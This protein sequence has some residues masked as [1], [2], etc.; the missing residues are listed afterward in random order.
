[1]VFDPFGGLLRDVLTGVEQVG[2]A[3]IGQERVR[4]A[5][6]G[7][8][9]AGKTVFLTSL[10]ANLL[11]AGRGQRTLAALQDAAGG[12]LV[13]ARLVPAGAE[14]VPRFDVH[15][16]LAA[17]AEDPPAWP[18]RTDDLSSLELVLELERASLFGG[19]LGPRTVTLELLDYPG[20]WLLDLPMLDQ[21]FADWSAATL[22]RLRAPERRPA[23]APFLAFL[24]A[25]PAAAPGEE[26]LARHG[27]GLYRDALRACR[28]QLGFRYL[29]PGRVLNPGPRGDAPILWFFPLPD[30]QA[31][32]LAGLLRR[33]HA[34]YVEEQRERFFDPFF[35]RFQRQ[36]VLVDVL[37]A[38]HAGPTAF[39]D[40]RDALGAIAGALREQDGILAR[41]FGFGAARVAF[42]ATKADHVPHRQREALVTLLGHLVDAAKAGALAAGTTTGV[43]ALAAVRCT[44]DAV[45]TLE[46]R[47]VAAVRGVLL[48]GGRSAKVYPG[49]VPLRPPDAAYWGHAY[50]EMPSFQPP[51]LDAAGRIGV[52]HLGMD[53]LLAW[54]IGDLL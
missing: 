28:D 43:H 16:H 38:L 25:L 50:F 47:P 13:G 8:T 22:E 35:R 49:E 39:A 15:G 21:S 42:V 53:A 4:L 2:R 30:G 48:D 54:L 36:A 46:G 26:A 27:F 9:R 24:D 14:S 20:E 5:I 31:G 19:L 3:A 32:G 10:V 34:A 18:G 41:L 11:A 6:T 37:G 45:A 52:P 29:Q 12:R 44:E 51:H 23:T 40:T 17:L 7:L 33:R 1:M